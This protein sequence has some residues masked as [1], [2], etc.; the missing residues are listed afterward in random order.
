MTRS[1]EFFARAEKVMPGGVNSPV[2]AFRSVGT[3]PIFINRASGKYIFDEDGN[4]YT[5]Y[6]GSWGP[7]ML[8]HAHPAIVEAVRKAAE[9]GTS[10]GLPTAMEVEMAELVTSLVP[11]V[12]M[13]RMVS[14]RAAI[15]ASPLFIFPSSFLAKS[16]CTSTTTQSAN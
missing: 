1:E 14:S 9:N 2:R 7:M 16:H 6:I 13:V 10:Y 4:R 12:E 11:S 8:G 3:S 15:S 5:D